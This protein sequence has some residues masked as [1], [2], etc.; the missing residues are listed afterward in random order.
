VTC[1]RAQPAAVALFLVYMND[2]TDHG[3]NLLLCSALIIQAI[4]QKIC[5]WRYT[6]KDF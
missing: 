2:F 4:V 3:G 5:I 1:L 6:G